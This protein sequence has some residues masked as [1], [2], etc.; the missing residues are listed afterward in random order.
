MLASL[1]ANIVVNYLSDDA[2]AAC[3]AREAESSGAKAVTVRADMGTMEGVHAVYDAAV[4]AFSRIDILI[5][6]AGVFIENDFLSLSEEDYDRTQNVVTK[7][8]FFLTQLV[9][10]NM[11]AHRTEGRI[12]NISS[13]ATIQIKGMPVDYCI[14]KSGVNIMTKALAEAL[15]RHGITV[16]AILPGSIP[17]K[18]NWWQFDNPILRQAMIDETALKSLGSAGY[19]AGAVRYL[20]SEEAKWT[21]GALIEVNGGLVF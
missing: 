20:V 18:I 9:A 15:G 21:T 10:E 4:K 13:S 6:N 12:I 11:I 14:A 8:T 19:I 2:A 17:T 7:G 1:K 5:N 16:N 3:V